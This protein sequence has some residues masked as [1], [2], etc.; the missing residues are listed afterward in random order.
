MARDGCYRRVN[1]F[2]RGCCYKRKI[3]FIISLL[4]VFCTYCFISDYVQTQINTELRAAA[5][6]EAG[7]YLSALRFYK[8]THQYNNVTVIVPVSNRGADMR[9]Q[10]RHLLKRLQAHGIR[11]CVIFAEQLDDFN[12][13]EKFVF[14][15]GWLLNTAVKQ[16]MEGRDFHPMLPPICRNSKNIMFHDVDV[17]EKQMGYIRYNQCVDDDI[18]HLYG[19]RPDSSKLPCMGGIFCMSKRTFVKVDGFSNSIEGWGYEDLDLGYRLVK[20]GASVNDLYRTDRN[21]GVTYDRVHD[22]QHVPYTDAAKNVNVG[23]VG[24][25]YDGLHNHE[26]SIVSFHRFEQLPIGGLS[27]PVLMRFTKKENRMQG[28]REVL[29]VLKN[30][31]DDGKRD[32][33]QSQTHTT[34]TA[35][36]TFTS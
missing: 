18:V 13:G 3:R 14:N 23:N 11:A 4:L 7:S 21:K 1:G 35:L 5:T 25:F 30:P 9:Y 26:S 24:K 33:T 29:Q 10:V 22:E 6:R 8:K 34:S 32:E 28:N 12:T 15:K 2:I 16:V 31:N 36:Q 27:V 17:W 20:S 19:H